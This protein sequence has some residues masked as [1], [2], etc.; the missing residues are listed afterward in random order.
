MLLLVWFWT[1]MI[2][3]KLRWFM[4]L[5]SSHKTSSLRCSCV[6]CWISGLVI[7][8]LRAKLYISTPMQPNSTAFLKAQ[9]FLL[10]GS[11]SV[12]EIVQDDLECTS[13]MKIAHIKSMIKVTCQNPD[14]DLFAVTDCVT[15]LDLELIWKE[16]STD[17]LL[18]EE[19]PQSKVTAVCA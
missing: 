12:W 1:V 18:A 6:R 19:V 3:V 14:P 4:I 17:L 7:F 11:C 8:V 5:F 16:C 10:I 2:S 9:Y 13:V 15:A